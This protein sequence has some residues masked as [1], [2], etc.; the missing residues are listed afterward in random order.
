MHY[1]GRKQQT[2]HLPPI[3]NRKH[4]VLG[5]VTLKPLDTAT[6]HTHIPD[7]QGEA[8]ELHTIM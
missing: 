8:L 3:G 1:Q 6:H 2:E 5:N 7:T 4:S